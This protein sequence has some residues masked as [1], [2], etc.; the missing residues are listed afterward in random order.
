MERENTLIE[1]F[2]TLLFDVTVHV[3]HM[4]WGKNIY[5][6]IN[7]AGDSNFVFHVWGWSVPSSDI[8]KGRAVMGDGVIELNNLINAVE[9]ADYLGPNEV[10]I[11]NQVI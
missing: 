9:R 4:W 1:S 3:F 2:Q 11:M 7:R 10:K 8:L 5:K 6:H